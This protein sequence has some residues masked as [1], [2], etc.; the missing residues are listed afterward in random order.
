[1]DTAAGEPRR[2]DQGDDP[3]S[4]DVGPGAGRDLAPSTVALAH[5]EAELAELEADLAALEAT[6]GGEG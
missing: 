4:G 6:D 3:G 5:L 1:M 2:D